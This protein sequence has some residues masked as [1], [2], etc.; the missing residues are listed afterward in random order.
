MSAPIHPIGQP[1]SVQRAAEALRHGALIVIPTDTVYGLAAM[2][3]AHNTLLALLYGPQDRDA[4]PA[5]PLLLDP[6]QP[7]SQLARTN[8]ATERL[9]ERFWPGAVTLLLPASAEFPVAIRNPQVAVRV[10]NF[11]P[12]WPL[13]RAVGGYLIVGRAA[14]S[15]YPSA[16]TAQEAADQLGEDVAVILDGGTP[17]FGITSTI[18]NCIEH[19]PRVV[20]RGAIAKEK[21]HAALNLSETRD[22]VA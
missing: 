18:V 8:R 7:L 21:I 14:R 11:P 3:Q 13:L 1:E 9:V 20:Q 10:P 19:P 16:I 15:G 5:L 2:P 6:H 22:G 17:T 12:L 4:W